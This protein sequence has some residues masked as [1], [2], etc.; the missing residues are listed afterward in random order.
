M[1]ALAGW[2]GELGTSAA[3]APRL[4]LAL[5]GCSPDIREAEQ[6][7]LPITPIFVWPSR[8]S[9]PKSRCW[10][11]EAADRIGAHRILWLG[12]A[13]RPRVGSY[14]ASLARPIFEGGYLPNNLRYAKSEEKQTRI[15]YEQT[16][17]R[18]GGGWKQGIGHSRVRTTEEILKAFA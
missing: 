1:A 15:S 11:R 10:A 13:G 16:I 2:M 14:A 9:L 18:A 3:I 5:L 8:C 6:R 7:L 17:Q 12:C 4:L